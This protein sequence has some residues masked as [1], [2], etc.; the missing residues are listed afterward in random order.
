MITEVIGVL[1]VFRFQI[2]AIHEHRSIVTYLDGLQAKVDAL[3]WLQIRNGCR[4]RRA[5]ALHS[6]QSLQRGA[7]RG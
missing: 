2:S 7:V 5:S 1:K 6:G 3:K 4:T